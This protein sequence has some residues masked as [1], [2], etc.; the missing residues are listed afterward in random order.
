ML[1]KLSDLHARCLRLGA[2]RNFTVLCRLLLAVGFIQPGMIK[3]MGI[4][5]TQISAE[6]PIGAFFAVFHGIGPWYAF[7]GAG[8]VLAGIMLLVPPLATLGALLYLPIIANIFVITLSMDF[9]G[10]P[11]I[12]GLMLLANVYLLCWDFDRLRVLFPGGAV[13]LGRPTEPW[14]ARLGDFAFPACSAATVI[15]G[16]GF[17]LFLSTL[18][19]NSIWAFG[20]LFL[21]AG[22]FDLIRGALGRR[23][24]PEAMLTAPP[25]PGSLA[26]A[27]KGGRERP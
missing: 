15:V 22:L 24:D 16:G 18:G 13:A 9:R 11:V 3:L 27:R 17:Y 26:A 5:F 6:T 10:T 20:S 19:P 25:R 23:N 21:V 8:Q 1:E 7:V 4:P 14:A 12:V 2:L